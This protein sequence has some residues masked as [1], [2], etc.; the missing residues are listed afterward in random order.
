[1]LQDF[2]TFV[3]RGN[4]MDLAVGV[5]IGAAFGGVVKS[6]VD[7]VIMPPIGLIIGGTDFG[8]HFVLLKEG[9]KA[10]PPY[11]TPAA[12]K[13][14]G[15]VTVNYG[16]FFGTLL[17]FFI[18]AFCVYLLVRALNRLQKVPAPAAPNTKPCAFCTLAIPLSATRCPNCTSQVAA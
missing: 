6:L 9:T 2:R 3:M 17:T 4:V 16:A 8:N 12:A 10:A 1:M 15:A 7:D 18:V 14:A 5:I 13:E 11:L